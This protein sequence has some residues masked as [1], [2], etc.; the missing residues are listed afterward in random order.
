[1]RKAVIVLVAGLAGALVVVSSLAQDPGG[2]PG[3]RGQ[4]RTRRGF[5]PPPSMAMDILDTDRDGDLSSDEIEHATKALKKLDKNKDGK[6]SREELRPQGPGARG[7]GGP[8]GPGPDGCGGP[9]GPPDGPSGPGG[10]G[11]IR[12]GSTDFEASSLPKDDVEKKILGVLREMGGQRTPGGA[13]VPPQDG[14]I[15][16]LLAES[17]GAKQVVEIGTSTGYSTVWLCL[18]L[19]DTKGKLTTYEIDAD[20]AAQA[21]KNFEKAGVTD[22]VTLVDGDAHDEVKKLKGPIDLLFLD[23][24][25]EGYLDYLEK[26]LPLVRP[27]GLIVA[28]NMNQHQA[29]PR[30]VKAITTNPGLETV[31]LNMERSGIG[32]SLKKR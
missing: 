24:D 27:G 17:I 6:L 25:K 18:A 13:N 5:P 14:R 4:S 7:P 11:G 12:T 10:R 30:Y 28:H 19:R 1:M 23:A 16:R 20:R 26:L 29:D 32:V 3:A 31:F 8:G 21:R 9:G 22:L 2:P 15:L